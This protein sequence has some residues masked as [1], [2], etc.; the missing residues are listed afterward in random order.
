MKINNIIYN[1]NNIL[2]YELENFLK[3]Y[4]S[5]VKYPICIQTSHTDVPHIVYNTEQMTRN[6]N[7][8]YHLINNFRNNNKIIEIW[9][10]S[11]TNIQILNK[12][13][14]Y[15]V[16]HIPLKIWPAYKN[17]ILSLNTDNTYH[18]D[19]GF[20]GWVHGNHRIDLLDKIQKS[21][22]TIDIIEDLY[23]DARDSR[24][25]RCKILLNIHYNKEYRIFEQLRCFPW[26]ETNKIVVSETSLDNDP[27]CI[28]VD[29]EN[30]FSTLKGLLN[31]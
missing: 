7:D 14:I 30:I 12:L 25:A 8:M 21:N 10:Y 20:C 27:R 22:I 3:Y 2:F 13:G 5:D 18:Y 23:K 4:Y 28:N 1:P 17:Q 16:K 29:Y 9:D 24:L 11:K 26:I 31:K 19:V 6:A 15:N